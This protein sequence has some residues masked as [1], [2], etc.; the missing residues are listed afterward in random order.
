VNRAHVEL[1]IVV[2]VF[3]AFGWW[4]TA[5]PPFTTSGTLGVLVAGIALIVVARVANRR[6]PRPAPLAHPNARVGLVI[7][8]V[9]LAL[10]LAWE[11]ITL[12]S[13]SR[14]AH[15]TV[16]SM[17]DPVQADHV[18]RWLLYGGWLGLGWTLAS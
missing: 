17:L 13:H 1:G 10:L 4:V 11:L 8:G 6:S 14:S 3:M 12:F 5:Q 2:A 16:S 7:W 15:P 9:L 18:A